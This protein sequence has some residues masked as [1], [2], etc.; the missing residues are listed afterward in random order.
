MKKSLIGIG[1]IL[2]VAVSL[3]ATTVGCLKG[4]RTEIDRSANTTS[5]KATSN[6]TTSVN[7]VSTNTSSLPTSQNETIKVPETNKD[8]LQI[9]YN[10]KLVANGI[11]VGDG[12]YVFTVLDYFNKD[13]LPKGGLYVITPESTFAASVQA[14]DPRTGATL[15]KIDNQRLSI[16]KLGDSSK[17]TIGQQV[18]VWGWDGDLRQLIKGVT[19]VSQ[20]PFGSPTRYE[21]GIPYGDSSSF[22]ALA[23]RAVVTD[24]EGNVIGIV[25][26][27]QFSIFPIFFPGPFIPAVV[28]LNSVVS[29]LSQ[30]VAQQP[31]ANGP[32]RLE[33]ASSRLFS[34]PPYPPTSLYDDISSELQV[35]FK[36]VGQPLTVDEAQKLFSETGIGTGNPGKYLTAAYA[37]PVNLFNSEGKMVAQ[38]RWILFTFNRNDGKPDCLIF[39]DSY[40]KPLGG[41]RIN[42][43]FPKLEEL[44]LSIRSM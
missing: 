6:N 16:A 3:T 22:R 13:Y 29:L 1:I 21:I 42:S 2:V 31:W 23:E 18:V 17:V 7:V 37:S 25:G 9:S 28:S 38:A 4:S 24:I 15:L 19:S 8:V 12:S 39:G 11:A 33:P 35:L 36:N 44:I 5:T 41:F 32:V 10:G 20:V 14:L 30:N 34:F 40:P 27:E 43:E 26:N